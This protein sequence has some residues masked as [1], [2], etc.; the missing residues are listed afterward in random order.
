MTFLILMVAACSGALFHYALR[1]S[2]DGGGRANAFL[3][4][5][6]FFAF[7]IVTAINVTPGN[8]RNL[9]MGTLNMGIAEGALYVAM[10]WVLGIAF[11]KGPPGLT[12][13]T[14]NSAA[15]IPAI[16]MA[17]IF[18]A[19]FGHGYTF[20][21]GVGSFLVVLGLFLAA[22]SNMT[23]WKVKEWAFFAS[24]A[25]IGHSIYLSIMQWRALLLSYD[26]IPFLSFS[27]SPDA[28]HWFQ[29]LIFLSAFV[30]QAVIYYVNDRRKFTRHEVIWS[31]IGGFSNG[32]CTWGLVQASEIATDGEK[33]MIF[34]IAGVTSI[35]LCN[36]WGKLL[37]KEKVNWVAISICL[38]G[39]FVGSFE[40]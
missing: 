1:K 21:N 25:F 23:E 26:E 22:R 11:Q 13:A 15:V 29:S 20:F 37:Y 39:I 40:W 17:I 34:P 8:F 30:I 35:F 3:F 5:Q 12:V 33:G 14:M 6:V 36:V 31:I 38:V 10:M 4:L 27:I 19:S 32:L 16:I 24:F 2:L 18:G 28:A 9:D 7:V